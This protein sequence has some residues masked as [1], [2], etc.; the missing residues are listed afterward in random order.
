MNTTKMLSTLVAVSALFL[1]ATSARAAGSETASRGTVQAKGATSKVVAAGPL[2][3]HAYSGFA[4]GTL[5]AAPAVTGTDADCRAVPAAG[6]T[7]PAD[8]VVSFHV[9]AGQVACLGTSG[10]RGFELLWHAAKEAAA[11]E[12]LIAKNGR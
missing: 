11:S 1:G 10:T 9:D 7:V 8:A 6:R 2:T 5:Y 12:V 4:G 3:F